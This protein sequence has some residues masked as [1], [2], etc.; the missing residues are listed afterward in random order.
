MEE[1]SIRDSQHQNP[2]KAWT[3]V[4]RGGGDFSITLPGNPALSHD[5][6]RTLCKLVCSLSLKNQFVSL[7]QTLGASIEV[8]T[9]EQTE[10]QTQEREAL[11]T[12]DPS[13]ERL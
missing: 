12:G 9:E 7:V 11:L 13:V 8:F 1:K 3:F 5:G 6:T 4:I 2:I 10:E